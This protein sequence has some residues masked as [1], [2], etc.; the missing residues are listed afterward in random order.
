M[1]KVF[2]AVG[3]LFVTILISVCFCFGASAA[4]LPAPD[5]EEGSVTS[6]SITLK[7]NK[8]K[9]AY[10]YKVYLYNESEDKYVSL[11]STKNNSFV[12]DELESETE[13]V[14]AVRPFVLDENGARD[15]GEL[16]DTLAITTKLEMV[17]DI[18]LDKATT[19]AIRIKWNKVD[20]AVKYRIKYCAPGSGSY[21]I[22]GETTSEKFTIKDLSG[23][24]KYKIRIS[25]IGKKSNSGYSSTYGFYCVPTRAEKPKLVSS[26]DHSVTVSWS[27]VKTATKYNVY[28]SQSSDG[29]YKLIGETGKTRFEYVTKKPQTAYYIKV[30]AV[31]KTARQKS[32]GKQSKALKAST[33]R[34]E[35]TAPTSVRCGEHLKVKAPYYGSKVKWSTSDSKIISISKNDFKARKTGKVKIT[36]SYNGSKSSVTVNV[37]APVLKYM[38]CVYDYTNGKYVFESRMNERCYPASITKLIT[39]L[40]AL[41]YMSVDDTVVVGSELNLVE[42][43]SSR[44]GIQYGEK[45]KLGDLLYGLL[46]PS[47]GDAAYT[48]A[49]NCARKVAKNPNMGYVDAK[50]YFVSLMNKYMKSIGAA[51]T[52]CVNPHGYPVNGH[53]TTVS[54]L[55][56]VAKKVL[57]NSALKKITSTYSK[58]VYDLSG[59]GRTWSTTNGLINPYSGFYS[60]YAHGLKTGTVDDNYTGLV[61]AATKNGRTIITV[62]V[63]CESYN[64]RYVATRTLYNYYL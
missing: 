50:N 6:E 17:S 60:P 38:S 7:W 27:K 14:F 1:K 41:Q 42:P 12:I 52:H 57:E 64:A 37:S 47:G 33:K 13:Y 36:A 28:A 26:T 15:F 54:D 45:Y 9:G 53:Y 21:K 18:K 23:G 51:G 20:S 5:L 24:G 10:A 55:V 3:F 2:T 34:I 16:S 56:L 48:I 58:Y 44:C 61:S 11:G 43:L 40:T 59:K 32:E 62:V 63:G 4:D 22:A 46:L 8:I 49:V 25:A 31:V 35:I 29:K 39:A 19:S 30:S